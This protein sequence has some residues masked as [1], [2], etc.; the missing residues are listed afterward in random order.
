MIS[1]LYKI[2]IKQFKQLFASVVRYFYWVYRL[3]RANIGSNVA[4]SFPLKVEGSGKLILGNNV[5][6]GKKISFG[7]SPGSIIKLGNG[8]SISDGANVHAGKNTTILLGENC[9]ILKHSIVRNGNGIELG[10]G[11]SISTYCQIFPRENGYDGKLIMGKGSNIGDNTQIDTC[12]DVIIHDQVAIGP[13]V[14]IYTHDHEYESDSFAAW[15]GGVKTGKVI[16]EDG[17][18]VGA[19]VT[20]LPGVTIGKRAIVAAG[21]VLTKSVEAGDIV[22]GIPAKSLKRK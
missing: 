16:V 8:S 12:D 22:G 17:A 5:S 14:I 2:G 21:S 18:W 9:N 10:D 15:K 20:L 6:L 11:S 7:L 4:I 3:S 1:N 13:Y 19:R